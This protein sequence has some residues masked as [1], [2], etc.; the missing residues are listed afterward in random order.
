[1]MV[2]KYN[3][4]LNDGRREG[5]VGFEERHEARRAPEGEVEVG[6]VLHGATADER[7]RHE[8]PARRVPRRHQPRP[9]Q[10]LQF[11]VFVEEQREAR[12]DGRHADDPG[13]QREL[14]L[15]GSAA[16][17][18]EEQRAHGAVLKHRAVVPPPLVCVV[19]CEWHHAPRG[20][21]VLRQ[22]PNV[23]IEGAARAD[24][25]PDGEERHPA[26]P[27]RVAS[28]VVVA[29]GHRG[30]ASRASSAKRIGPRRRRREAQMVSTCLA[31]YLARVQC[32]AAQKRPVTGRVLDTSK[33][34]LL[35][36]DMLSCERSITRCLVRNSYFSFSTFA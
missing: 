2:N 30:A 34:C 27:S 1:M 36:Q 28:R 33:T 31:P 5:D 15:D 17:G 14:G 20:V 22:V 16:R 19:G 6:K 24:R 4:H 11:D 26:L 8:R 25:H 18:K 3:L 21:D 10:R 13:L 23:V 32:T 29:P 35:H 7:L 9:P 12:L